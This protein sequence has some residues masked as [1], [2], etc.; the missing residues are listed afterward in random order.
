MNRKNAVIIAVIGMLAIVAIWR[1]AFSRPSGVGP[2][3]SGQ[4]NGEVV[5]QQQ[6]I[7]RLARRG[8]SARAE[9]RQILAEAEQPDVKAVAIQCLAELYDYESMDTI[10]RALEDESP[11]VRRRAKAAA[12]RMTG[13]DLVADP[14]GSEAERRKIIAFYHDQWSRLKDSR[15]LAQFRE[16]MSRRLRE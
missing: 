6:E 3:A 5:Q 4:I 2:D 1:M 13:Y 15:R 10:L 11:I 14:D 12:A 8:Q 7:V 16:Q 9:I